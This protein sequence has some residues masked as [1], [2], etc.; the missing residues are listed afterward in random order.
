MPQGKKERLA[1]ISLQGIEILAFSL[2]HIAR[3]FQ[4]FFLR[5]FLVYIVAAWEANEMCADAARAH[6]RVD[7][8]GLPVGC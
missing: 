5:L 1:S 3:K 8:C 2:Y 4:V 6:K 7:T